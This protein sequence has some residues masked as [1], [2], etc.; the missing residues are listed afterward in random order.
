MTHENTLGEV[1]VSTRG[2]L[3]VRK[4][5][6]RDLLQSLIEGLDDYNAKP[7]LVPF[8]LVIY[9]LAAFLWTLFNIGGDLVHLAFPIVSGM[10]LL[11]PVVAVG[12]F[13][14]SRRREQQLELTWGSAFGFV[15]SSSFAGIIVLSLIMMAL[16]VA[17]LYMA[18]LIYFGLFGVTPPESFSDFMHQILTTRHGEALVFYGTAVGF[19]FAVIALAVSVVAFPLLLDKDIGAVSAIA[20]SVKAVTS[21]AG[22]MAVW[23]ILV[24]TLLAAGAILFLIGLCVVLPVL[25]HGTW[26]LYRKLIDS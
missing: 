22:V 19:I 23:G 13:E 6:V 12:L 24:V 26:H 11:G 1:P 25:A 4:I 14:L 18:Q 21:N 2:N 10:T 7:S 15:R 16:Y 8:L 5:S 17:W 9:P 20:T 3:T